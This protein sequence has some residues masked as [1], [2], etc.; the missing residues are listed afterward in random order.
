MCEDM[1]LS[2]LERIRSREEL[3][4]LSAQDEKLLCEE[5]RNFLINRVADSG[6][7]LASN[8]GIVE[9]TV[10]IHKVFDTAVDRLI[11][12]VGH[13]SY[14]HKILTGR[15]TEFDKLRQ[16]GGISGFPKP[17]ES[18]HDAFIAGHASNAVSVALGMARARTR[19]GEKHHVIALMGDGALTGGL[20][21]E[22]LNDVGA[23]G[24]PLIIIL[25]DNG[26]SI[27]RN[28]GGMSKHLALLRLKPGYFGFKRAFHRF[29][30]AVPGGKFLDR[31]AHGVK[32]FLKRSLIG[33]TVFE[34]MGLTYLGPVD[35]HDVEKV[36]Y[37][38]QVAK[39]ADGPVLVHVITKKGKGYRLA[40]SEP[41][42]Y[43]GVGH[44]NPEIGVVSA[45][46]AE[47]Y[48]QVFGETLCQLAQDDSKICAITAA[49]RQGTGLDAFS[50]RFPE[51]F[52]DVG[53]AEG[54][55]VSMAAGMAAGGSVPVVAL[56]STFLQR[57]FDMLLHDVA[58]MQNHV[59]F[60]VDRCGLVGED[61]ATHHGAFDVG[62]LSQVPNLTILSPAT[63][64]ELRQAL[65]SAIYDYSGPVAIRYPRGYCCARDDVTPP[66]I[67]ATPAVTLI[68]YG[69]IA[70]N[71][72]RAA[73]ILEQNNVPC[74]VLRLT[75]IKPL[76]I[77]EI[78]STVD[79][80][81]AVLVVEETSGY[82]CIGKTIAAEILARDIHCRTELINLGDAF[83]T[84]GTNSE[85]YRTVGLD[86]ESI[87][88]RALEV[89]HN[90][91]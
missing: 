68:T 63:A 72:I 73:G 77:D 20:S 32:S 3:A 71:V 81:A 39:E 31:M 13:Q 46:K 26:M 28:V 67:P 37:L 76:H 44:F 75:K 48:S 66:E 52:Y 36:S 74:R 58:L 57:A 8:L 24:E 23:S 27:T 17:E 12:D 33:T 19:A 78:L 43:H 29:T 88:K 61:G 49:M 11:F 55:A 87:A 10:A 50:E 6:G 51:R 47:S 91:K 60:A 79:G 53:I 56:Y 84:H 59:I 42:N 16:F 80:S 15:N 21:Y 90:E 69:S 1:I 38:L 34:E 4:G 18:V 9:T 2:I 65:R 14:V 35:G 45:Q 30:K 25:N 83:V 62:Y 7:H 22:G 41:Q 89:L 40:E 85:L 54:H 82:G 64:E 86:A 70:A 5:I